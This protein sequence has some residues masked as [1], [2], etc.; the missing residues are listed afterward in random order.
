MSTSIADDDVEESD[1][2]DKYDDE[3][4]DDDT[5]DDFDFDKT[6]MQMTMMQSLLEGNDLVKQSF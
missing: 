2:E 4:E 5:T 3:D 6:I 1:D